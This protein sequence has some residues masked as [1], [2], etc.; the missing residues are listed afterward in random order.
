M[1]QYEY[2]RDI[3]LSGGT[4]LTTAVTGLTDATITT[5]GSEY[6]FFNQVELDS[7]GRLK[8]YIRDYISPTPTPTISLTPTPTP[9]ITPTNTPTPTPT[10]LPATV[11]YVNE[12]GK[13]IEQSVYNFTVTA[14]TNSYFL[15][16]VS[17]EIGSGIPTVT[18][19]TLD[20]L[21][22]TNL[23][24]TNSGAA[25]VYVGLF[26]LNWTGSSG[27]YTLTVTFGQNQQRAGIGYWRLRDLVSTTPL[28]TAVATQVNP[29][30][31]NIPS[32]TAQSASSL[33]IA[34]S[35]NETNA[36][37]TWTN[38]TENFDSN[39][40]G[41]NTQRS[42]ASIKFTTPPFNPTVVMS[43]TSATRVVGVVFR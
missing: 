10:P 38:I 5:P 9:T 15:V 18:S 41:G 23:V 31:F 8:I 20:G 36:T 19:V 42:G 4:C 35:T 14:G 30:T 22:M 40:D 25:G 37:A 32:F 6:D 26:G 16:G 21:N 1:N 7:E 33:C 34:V 13:N 39:T 28:A 43:N 12:M 17:S 27:A 3:Q 24:Q 29:Q 11:E 2:Y